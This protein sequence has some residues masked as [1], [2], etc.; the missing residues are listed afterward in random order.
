MI[1]KEVE[2]RGEYTIT[3][4]YSVKHYLREK[5]IKKTVKALVRGK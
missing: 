2:K 4:I 3:T 1:I 5:G